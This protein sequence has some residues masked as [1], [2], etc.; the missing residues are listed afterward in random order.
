VED[1]LLV[2]N[3]SNYPRG[4]HVTTPWQPIKEATGIPAG[5]L[6]VYD[7]GVEVPAQVDQIDPSDRRLDTLAIVLGKSL[8]SGPEDYSRPSR[9]VFLKRGG[10]PKTGPSPTANP[11]GPP[12]RV[13]LTNEKL[14]VSVSLL[15]SQAPVD[16]ACFAGAAQSFR[17]GGEAAYR[18]GCA[19]V[20]MLDIWRSI[21]L[22]QIE[23]DP[24]KRCMQVDRI[25]VPNPPWSD[26]H[27]E[28]IELFRLPYQLLSYCTGPVRQACTIVSAPFTYDVRPDP[29]GERT[30]LMECRFYRTLILYHGADYLLEELWLKG[31][32]PEQEGDW[33][34]LRFSAHYFAQMDLGREPAICWSEKVPDWFALGYPLGFVRPG[35]GFATDVH[36]RRPRWPH[37][38]YPHA[39]RAYRAFSWELHPCMRARCLH[40]FQINAPELIEHRIG[41]AWYEELYK[42]LRA[43][44]EGLHMPRKAA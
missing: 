18:V 37:P 38:G 7:D 41:H 23:H 11:P 14:A 29:F 10:A 30:V 35:Y 24:E 33:L 22:A 43:A 34:D 26:R 3:P 13:E 15:P 44:C 21:M 32:D 4:G 20:E 12:A 28:E 1:R 31:K 19:E 27:E 9:S 39:D 2:F 16:P 25:I 6:Q 8:D 42:P 5:K 36:S 40:L 17:L